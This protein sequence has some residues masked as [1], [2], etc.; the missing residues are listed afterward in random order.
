MS[1]LEIAQKRYATKTYRNEKISEAK[2]Q[3]IGR[4]TPPI[5]FLKLT[6]SHGNLLS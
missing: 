3:G 6:V 2:S 1:F 5:T 4:D